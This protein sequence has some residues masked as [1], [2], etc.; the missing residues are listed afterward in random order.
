MSIC[1]RMPLPPL[2]ELEAIGLA[3]ARFAPTITLVPAFGLRALPLS[4]RGILGIA[5]GAAI[6][7]ALVPIAAARESTPWVL[8][9]LEQIVLGVPVALACAIPLWAATMAGGLVDSLRGAQ[10][11]AG[12]A[13]VEGQRASPFGVLLS[14]LASIIFLSTGG[15]ARVA[16]TLAT[17]TLSTHPLEAAATAIVAGI[18]LAVAIGG[19]L[20]ASAVV[21]EVAFALIARAASPAQVH[22]LL[23]PLR[24]LG[25]LAIVAIVIERLANVIG[26]AVRATP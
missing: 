13:V 20:L 1:A 23:A 22:A 5:L 10:E 7:P 26:I 8:L 3:W 4:A 9:A 21:L 15:P 6:Y 24:A 16:A 25:L 17:T 2:T 18:G 14:L 11:G 12:L 19:P